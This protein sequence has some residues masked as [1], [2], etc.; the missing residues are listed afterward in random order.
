MKNDV[1]L[2]DQLRRHGM[3]VDGIN[4]VMKTLMAFEVLYIS[5]R[6]S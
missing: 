5:D 3:I 6:T 2:I 4:R 1:A